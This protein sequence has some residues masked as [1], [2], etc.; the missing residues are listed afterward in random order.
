[1]KDRYVFGRGLI[2]AALLMF[3]LGAAA[4]VPA[5]AAAPSPAEKEDGRVAL[6]IVSSI[7]DEAAMLM[8]G[9]A[10]IGLAAAVRRAA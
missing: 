3:S 6:Q 8:V 2:K 10:M 5:L 7:P 9:T 1:V 4:A